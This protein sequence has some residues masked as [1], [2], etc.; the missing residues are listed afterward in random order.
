MC[1]GILSRPGLFMKYWFRLHEL[2]DLWETGLSF[3]ALTTPGNMTPF[4][5]QEP[6]RQV[7]NHYW[8]DR[9][10]QQKCACSANTPNCPGSRCYWSCEKNVREIYK[11]SRQSASWNRKVETQLAEMNVP[12]GS[13]VLDIGAG[14]G[15]LA[16][17]LAAGGCRVTVIEPSEPMREGL[18]QNQRIAGSPDIVVIPKRWEEVTAEE[19]GEP[20]DVVI[21]SYSLTM[22]DIR[23]SLERMQACCTG[24]V[25]LF[26]FLTPPAWVK[27]SYALWPQLHGIEYTGEPLADCLWQVLR[28]MGIY[29]DILVEQKKK[30]TFYPT[31]EDAVREYYQRLNCSTPAQE[32]IL[33]EYFHS[34]LQHSAG[35]YQLPGDSR[36]AHIR[37][38]T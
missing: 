15:T 20:Y 30:P 4:P 13:R 11:K 28:E 2:S 22:T 18:A 32:M 31:I 29:A 24:T 35:G 8:R 17:P 14:T 5:P 38:E 12:A 7:N 1:A 6:I 9:W 25:H 27:V 37:W 34:N 21:A 19:L 26:W 36:G 3:S 16:I 33:Y 10:Q 23:E